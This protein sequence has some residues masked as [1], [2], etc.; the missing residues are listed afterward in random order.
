MGLQT[1]G[2]KGL[3]GGVEN[4]DD[5]ALFEQVEED[6]QAEASRPESVG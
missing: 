2:F 4:T 1:P 6:L 3:Y 5:A